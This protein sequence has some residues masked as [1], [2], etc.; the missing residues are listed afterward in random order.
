M[1]D[2]KVKEITQQKKR[3]RETTFKF[4]SNKD[5]FEFNESVL[6]EL[7]DVS[8]KGRSSKRKLKK[9]I[10]RLVK[11]NKFIK[12][13][14]RSKA[15]WKIVKEYLTD[16]IASDEEDAKKMKV[17]EK[18]ALDKIA[19]EKEKKKATSE[20]KYNPRY[21]DRSPRRDRFRNAS[22][23]TRSRRQD[24]CFRCG[25]LGHWEIDCYER[26]DERPRYSRK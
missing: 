5:Q 22:R 24:A 8:A 15:G 16:D 20:R 19:E 2:R 6:A 11:R 18:D 17:A 9:A 25:K 12:M 4:P 13:A 14:D 1:I 26:K 21:T 7:E 10:K 23:Q 3:K